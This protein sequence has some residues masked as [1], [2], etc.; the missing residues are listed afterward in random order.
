[1]F[2]IAIRADGGE[3]VGM[4]HVMRCLAVAGELRKLGCKVYF[5]GK[6]RQGLDKASDMG[7]ETF[8]IGRSLNFNDNT[9]IKDSNY[10]VG[11]KTTSGFDYGS[12]EELEEDL[13][14]TRLIT[15]KQG[16]DLLLVDKYNLTADY[17]NRL[18]EFVAKIAFID[19]L[20]IFKCYADIIIN[21][22]ANASQL[23]YKEELAGQKLLLGNNFTP[24]RKEF[25][26]IP[27]R[28][29]R[30]FSNWYGEVDCSE[31]SEGIKRK[32]TKNAESCPEIMITTGGAD[33]YDCTGRLIELLLG[34]IR[35]AR[36]R[37]NV[38][39][40]SGFKYKS[41]IQRIAERNPNIFLYINPEHISE[42]MLRSDLAISSGGS[43]LYELCC[44][45]TPTLAF[46]MAD[47]QTGIV[48]SLSDIGYIHGLGWH[49]QIENVNITEMVSDLVNNLSSRQMYAQRMQSLVDGK[50][51]P[52]IAQSIVEIL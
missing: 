11:L 21:G 10:N 23:G 3:Q 47:N 34:D 26:N 41:K 52:R 35:T 49:N 24:L 20:N 5:L 16:C 22:N 1:M 45:G 6:Y 37:Y 2:N 18:R 9:E 32:N 30:S 25:A 42:I 31:A 33:P 17:F 12:S 43:T 36:M 28:Q 15:E 51:A 46:I 8:D 40:G 48:N 27:E 50:G 29:I 14:K 39:I 7:F 38:V 13:K 19:D 4:G 44:C